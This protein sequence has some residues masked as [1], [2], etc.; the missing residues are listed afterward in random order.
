MD[1]YK[2]ALSMFEGPFDLLL[3]LIRK[4]EID[5]YDIP[6]SELIDQYLEYLELIQEIDLDNAAEFIEMAATLM[7]IK[8]KLLLPGPKLLSDDESGEEEDPRALLV[9]QLLTYRQYRDAASDLQEYEGEQRQKFSRQQ[10]P[11]LEKA[12]KASRPDAEEYLHEVT[13]FDLMIALKRALDNMPKLTSHV[14]EK[15]DI[16]VEEQRNL[17]TMRL[18]K[19]TKITFSELLQDV[20]QRIVAMVTFLAVLEMT[21]IGEIILLQ[22]NLYGE[23]YIARSEVESNVEG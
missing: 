18:A 20:K 6:I 10:F 12:L 2:V 16:T 5:I 14:V 23:I 15:F 19:Q 3:F 11:D 17:I 8:A 4:N 9:K 1:P 13:L 7:Q 22:N 21:K